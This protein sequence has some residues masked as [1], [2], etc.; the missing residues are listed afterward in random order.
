MC[1]DAGIYEGVTFL[2]QLRGEINFSMIFN[3]LE[4]HLYTLAT[5][6]IL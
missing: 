6:K 2:I 1:N 3:F 4:M 5:L